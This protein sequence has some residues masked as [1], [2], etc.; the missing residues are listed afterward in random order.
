[1]QPKAEHHPNTCKTKLDV[2]MSNPVFMGMNCNMN[3]YLPHL[4]DWVE[5]LNRMMHSVPIHTHTRCTVYT[6]SVSQEL[7]QTGLFCLQ[8]QNANSVLITIPAAGKIVFHILFLFFASMVFSNQNG[9]PPAYPREQIGS[10]TESYF[11]FK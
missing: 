9:P 10:A 5:A 1:M 8:S 6:C 7:S 2:L 4:E 3:R 11:H